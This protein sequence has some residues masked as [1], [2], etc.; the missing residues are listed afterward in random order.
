MY[1]QTLLLKTLLF[2]Q[3]K[4][5]NSVWV[6]G[7]HLNAVWCVAFSMYVPKTGEY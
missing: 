7:E 6:T 5:K 3:E 1:M 4:L 2:I